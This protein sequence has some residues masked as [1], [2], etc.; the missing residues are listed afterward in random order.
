MAR[1]PLVAPDRI[2]KTETPAY[3]AFPPSPGKG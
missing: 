2:A 1:I 3:A